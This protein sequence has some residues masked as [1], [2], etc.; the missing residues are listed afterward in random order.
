MGM[1]DDVV[2]KVTDPYERKARLYPALLASAPLFVMVALLYGANASAL[3]SAFTIAISCGGLYLVTNVCRECGKRLEERLYRDWGGKPSTQLLRHRDS[4][5]EAPTKKRYHTFLAGK[6]NEVFPDA[7]QE[8]DDPFRA[9]A[10]YQSGV[11]WL[12]NHTRPDDSKRFELLFRENIAYGFR[13]NAL[14]I[15]PIGL[16]IDLASMLWPLLKENVIGLAPPFFDAA[17]ITR[18]PDNATACVIVSAVM[19]CAWLFFFT[20]TSVRAAAF[21]YAEMLLRTC[22]V[23][24]TQDNNTN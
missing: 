8:C 2:A 12:L 6:I 20:K 1:I 13:R 17:A 3:K 15:K 22:D 4:T 14:G 18:M 10:I 11:R 16:I 24:G 21:A 5:I 19:V 9:D 23:V 7:Q